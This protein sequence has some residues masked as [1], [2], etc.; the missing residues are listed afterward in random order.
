V[1]PLRLVPRRLSHGSSANE[2][3]VY[4]KR[5]AR[6][7][8]NSVCLNASSAGAAPLSARPS[9]LWCSSSSCQVEGE[10]IR[11]GASHRRTSQRTPGG[12]GEG[13]RTLVGRR[14]PPRQEQRVGG[15]GHVDRCGVPHALADPLRL[16][17]RL[18]DLIITAVSVGSCLATE[19]ISQKCLRRPV[20]NQGRQRRH[21]RSVARLRDPSRV[22]YWM[23]VLGGVIAIFVTKQ[24]MGGSVT[25]FSTLPSSAG[26]SWW[27]PIRW[28]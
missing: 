21:H 3:G 20:T 11:T 12:A 14:L 25:T 5:P 13:N 4:V 23:P 15:K 24:L 7:R 27:R 10:K 8:R 9:G 6:T 16:C 2:I 26:L 1:H 28:P 18:P 17:F 19:A 22:P